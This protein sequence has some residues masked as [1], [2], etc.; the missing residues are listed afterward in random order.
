MPDLK[1]IRTF[2]EVVEGGSLTRAGERLAISKSMVSRRLARLE[3]ELG[4]SLLA[5]S[6]RGL[7][8]T[9]AGDDFRPHALRMVAEMQAARKS[10]SRDGRVSG[11]LRLT[12]PVSFGATHLAP[13]LAGLAIRNPDLEIVASFSDR[14]VDLV[15]EG[16]D[17]AIRL[18]TLANSALIARRIAPVR[19]V[20]VAAPAYLA[21]AGVPQTPEAL[22]GHEAVPHGDQVWQLI[23]P[24]GRVASVRPR[25]RFRADSG[26]AELAAVVAGLGVAVMPRF[27]VAAAIARGEV[28][29][30][31]DDHAVPEAGLYIVRPPPADPVPLKIRV[32]TDA[33]I[34]Q[35]GHDDWDLGPAGGRTWQP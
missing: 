14:V 32:L 22:A 34:A 7:S 26:A 11:R 9:E 19:A 2:C 27:M 28:V 18:G 6:T 17:V 25:G 35:F 1:D 3:A 29:T 13:V 33:V 16:F 12:G 5:R 4:V 8:L 23:R 21:R 15:S 24:D 30:L 31:L 20:V 10:L